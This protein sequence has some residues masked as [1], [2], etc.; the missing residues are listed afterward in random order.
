MNLPD[1]SD[2]KESSWNAGELGSVP[3][4]GSSPGEGKGYPLHPVSWPGEFHGLYSPWGRKGHDWATF[5]SLHFMIKLGFPVLKKELYS[6]MWESLFI[7]NELG[8]WGHS[9]FYNWTKRVVVFRRIV[10]TNLGNEICDK[11]ND[12]SWSL[13][14][15]QTW[16][17]R[18]MISINV[19][20]SLIKF[21][22]CFDLLFYI[23]I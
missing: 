20:S 12:V 18:S 17:F 1:G 5:T 6:Q 23:V 3:G 16:Y 15:C 22:C 4:L 10:N 11:V 2:G 8:I 19:H 7:A 21:K 9:Q 13:T 14:M